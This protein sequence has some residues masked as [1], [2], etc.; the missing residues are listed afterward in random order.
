MWIHGVILLSRE[1]FPLCGLALPLCKIQDTR[2]YPKGRVVS[3]LGP[4]QVKAMN[5]LRMSLPGTGI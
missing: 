2:G 1:L 4:L 3:F 5:T